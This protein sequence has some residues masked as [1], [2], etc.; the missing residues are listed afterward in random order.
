MGCSCC[1]STEPSQADTR[2]PEATDSSSLPLSDVPSTARGYKMTDSVDE[3]N[4][5]SNVCCE[6][7]IAPPAT[8]RRDD[9]YGRD[10]VRGNTG[11]IKDSS[12]AT[13]LPANAR[14]CSDHNIDPSDCCKGKSWSESP[15]GNCCNDQSAEA[16]DRIDLHPRDASLRPCRGEDTCPTQPTLRRSNE[17]LDSPCADCC[18]SPRQPSLPLT[19][20]DTDRP[21]CCRGKSSPCC[22]DACLDRLALRECDA[23]SDCVRDWAEHSSMYKANDTSSI[24]STNARF[25]HSVFINC[26]SE[27][28][29][30]VQAPSLR[31]SSVLCT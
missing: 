10:S 9:S 5:A 21:D 15:A 26:D 7:S 31:P 13:A 25:P 1:G 19:P 27:T 30:Y 28:R 23:T 8:M 24:R 18:S 16:V 2:M 22:D 3:L 14:T 20:D 11:E 29:R 12:G 17:S 6:E 4:I